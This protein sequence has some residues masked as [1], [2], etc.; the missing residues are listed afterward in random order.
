M[1]VGVVGVN[2]VMV[3]WVR[4]LTEANLKEEVARNFPVAAADFVEKQGIE[5]RFT[6]ISIGAAI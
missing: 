1:I 2:F 6:T 5:D 3:G 4:D